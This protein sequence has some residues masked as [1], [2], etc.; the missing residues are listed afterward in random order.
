MANTDQVAA[1]IDNKGRVTLPKH[2]REALGIEIGDTVFLKYEPKDKQVRLAPAISPFD[3][4]AE[5]A[6]EEYRA[7]STRPIEEFAKEH[8]IPL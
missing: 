7:G 5:H 4:L 1:K 6:I 8:N 3:I 2:M